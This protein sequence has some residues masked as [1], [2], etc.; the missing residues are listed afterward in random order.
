MSTPPIDLEKDETR[1]MEPAI[2]DGAV[3]GDEEPDAALS[4][5]K[6]WSFTWP[7]VM[8]RAWIDE[9]FKK[10][11]LND[12]ENAFELMGFTNVS[13]IQGTDLRLWSLLDIKVVEPGQKTIVINIPDTEKEQY[14]SRYVPP[15]EKFGAIEP[16]LYNSIA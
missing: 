15:L 8:A 9:E 7:R 13:L 5:I 14:E 1:N 11:L 4:V 16:Y 3:E 6:D 2:G 10:L 12:A